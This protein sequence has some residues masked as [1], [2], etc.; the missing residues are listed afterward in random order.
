MLDTS[1]AEP[2]F[3]NAT[4]DGHDNR[5]NRIAAGY[6]AL[7]LRFVAAYDTA[8]EL[9]KGLRKDEQELT[10][11]HEYS[12]AFR[13]KPDEGKED[14]DHVGKEIMATLI[15][16]AEKSFGG[17]GARLSINRQ[18]EVSI[19][20]NVDEDRRRP[21]LRADFMPSRF[22]AQLEQRYG[23]AKGQTLA[24]EQAAAVIVDELRLLKKPEMRQVG[25]AVEI[26]YRISTT[27]GISGGR[28]V[29]Y[30]YQ[31]NLANL[32][33]ALATFLIWA[34]DPA[35]SGEQLK[36]HLTAHLGYSSTFKSRDRYRAG[37]FEVIYFYEKLQIRIAFE[38]ADKLN[39]FVSKYSAALRNA[40]GGAE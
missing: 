14:K 11:A 21:S 30:H 37:P 22:W 17:I 19:W 16:L 26:E 8:A 10:D 15:G 9:A 33:T 23:G 24:Y 5:L 25:G 27:E 38:Y 40:Q 2:L 29:S 3:E 34:G 7:W 32:G 18:D 28:C 31:S 6:D 35:Y 36:R 39:A 20:L 12:L 13:W 4:A 1:A